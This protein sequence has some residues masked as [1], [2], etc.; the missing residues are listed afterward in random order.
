MTVGGR[1]IGSAVIRAVEALE[2]VSEVCISAGRPP[3]HAQRDAID[4]QSLRRA[5]QYG[6][7]TRTPEKPY[8]YRAAPDW[9]AVLSPM[10]VDCGRVS[11]VWDLAAYVESTG[12]TR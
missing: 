8:V 9:R 10:R 7:V 5:V 1:P 4:S 12:E 2:Q 6:M 11:S 3:K